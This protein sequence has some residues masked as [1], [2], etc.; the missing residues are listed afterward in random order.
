VDFIGSK[1]AS[2]LVKIFGERFKKLYAS[3]LY[4][5]KL[6]VVI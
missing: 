2:V 4:F 3:L 1:M 6:L 5:L